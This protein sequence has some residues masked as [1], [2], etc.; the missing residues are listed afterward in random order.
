MTGGADRNRE[1][2]PE[3]KRDSLGHTKRKHIIEAAKK[4]DRYRGICCVYPA[5]LFSVI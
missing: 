5:F 2:S 4:P 1:R 3:S